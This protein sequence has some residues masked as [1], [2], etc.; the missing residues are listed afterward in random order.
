MEELAGIADVT[1]THRYLPSGYVYISF[2]LKLR[3][4][5]NLARK[6]FGAD[7]YIEHKT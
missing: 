7:T 6:T 1:S 4:A 2:M 5:W 3:N